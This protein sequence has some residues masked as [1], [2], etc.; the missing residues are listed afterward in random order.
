MRILFC[1]LVSSFLNIIFKDSCFKRLKPL[2][3]G[4][5]R[6]D[7]RKR[8][9]AWDRP[10]GLTL[11]FEPGCFGKRQNVLHGAFPHR[12]TPDLKKSCPFGMTK[13]KTV[14]IA[15]SIIANRRQVHYI[16][17]AGS[18]SSF[19]I[20]ILSVRVSESECVWP[21]HSLASPDPRDERRHVRWVRNHVT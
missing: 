11:G 10:L 12:E 5:T 8:R 4:L 19:E 18:Q 15:S 1:E 9:H 14:E 17:T 16:A 6:K 20:I 13:G 21:S 2:W 3:R 7:D